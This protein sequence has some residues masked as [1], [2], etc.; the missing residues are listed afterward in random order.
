MVGIIIIAVILIGLG[1]H[2]CAE[3]DRITRNVG[4]SIAVIGVIAAVVT[5]WLNT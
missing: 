5:V 2:W 4:L 1:I 3:Y